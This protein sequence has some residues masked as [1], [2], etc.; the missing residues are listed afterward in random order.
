MFIVIRMMISR[1]APEERHG[2]GAWRERSPRIK[3]T[4]VPLLRS[5]AGAWSMSC[6]KH[7]APNGAFLKMVWPFMIFR[8]LTAQ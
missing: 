8:C 4:L 6:Y 1:Q 2:A 5:L 7:G 3:V